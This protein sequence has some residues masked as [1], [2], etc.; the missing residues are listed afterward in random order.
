MRE[1]FHFL[2]SKKICQGLYYG[3]DHSAQDRIPRNSFIIERKRVS[4]LI[5]GGR[6]G[7][8][9]DLLLNGTLTGSR[10]HGEIGNSRRCARLHDAR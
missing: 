1:V 7:P 2:S 5:N 3:Y 9:V 10:C 8:R 6:D 4:L